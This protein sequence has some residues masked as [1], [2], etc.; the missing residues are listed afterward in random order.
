M[1]P[2]WARH[3]NASDIAVDRK[4]IIVSFSDGRQHRVTVVN[5]VDEY[6]LSAIVA[7]PS[8]VAA[9]PDLA[10]KVW[11]KNRA[12][13]LV[14]FRIDRRGQ[15][16]GETWVPKCG[17]TTEEFQLYLRTL[18]AEADRFEYSLTGRDKE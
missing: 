1:D 14:G 4:G 12:V 5:E 10:L 9:I 18:A 6:I 11:V 2:D 8:T 15:L 3:C 7:R 16:I 13:S 17:I